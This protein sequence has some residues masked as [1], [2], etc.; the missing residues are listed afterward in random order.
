MT[1]RLFQDGPEHHDCQQLDKFLAIAELTGTIKQ[2]NVTYKE[3]IDR[4]FEQNREI[5]VRLDALTIDVVKVKMKFGLIGAAIGGVSSVIGN[6]II[7]YLRSK[8]G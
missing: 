1:T 2:T 5:I 4:L 8:V 3:Q 6:L 7:V